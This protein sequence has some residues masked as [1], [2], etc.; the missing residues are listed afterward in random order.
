[1]PN[2]L[3]LQRISKIIIMKIFTFY[4]FFSYL[5]MQRKFPDKDPHKGALSDISFSLGVFFTALTLFFLIETNIWWHIQGTWDPSLVE[6]SRYN[7]Y[8][9]S[10]I[11]SVLGWFT[12]RKILSWYFSRA[13]CMYYL[14]KYYLPYNEIIKD[15]TLQIRLLFIYF[16][17]AGFS[18]YL[19]YLWLGL[20]GLLPILSIF[21]CVELWI[22]YEFEWSVDKGTKKND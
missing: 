16:I 21:V 10:A 22:H 15:Y 8:A 9:P 20:Y 6:P 11:I 13:D 4:Y 17:F 1:M 7:P 3:H 18:T 2:K 19:L 14:K 12:S 5:F